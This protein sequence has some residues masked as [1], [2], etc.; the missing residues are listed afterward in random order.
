MAE[1][2]I[3]QELD[4]EKFCKVNNCQPVTNPVTFIKGGKPTPD[5]LLSE[6]IFGITHAERYGIYAYIDLNGWFLQPLAYKR[7]C[8]LNAKAKAVIYGTQTFSIKSGELIEDP[9]GDTGIR[10]L[11]TNFDKI[12]WS[13][14]E[15]DIAKTSMQYIKDL[16]KKNTLWIKKFPIIPPGYRDVTVTSKGVSIGELNQ[17]YQRLLMHTNALKQAQDYGLSMMTNAEGLIQEQMAS[18]F[19]WFG[20]GTTIGRDVTSNNLPGKTGIIRRSVLAKTTDYS[21]R[22]VITAP[23]N[24]VEDLD[25]IMVDMDHAAIPLA[26]AITC[27]KPFIL[28]WLRRFFEN[29]FAGKNFYNIDLYDDAF[30]VHQKRV[31]VPIKDYQAVF[32]DAELEKQIDRFAKGRYNRLIPIQVP[33]VDG[34][35]KKYKE[36]KGRKPYLYFTGYNI[37]G[38]ELAEARANNFEFNELIRRPLTWCDLFYMAA[39]DMTSDKSV[40]ITRFPMD[41]YFNQF[42]Q[43]INVITTSETVSMVVDGKFYKWYPKFNYKDIGKNTSAM[44]VDT[45]SI[46]NATIG[47]AGGDYDGDTVTCKPIFSIEANAEVRKQLNNIGNYNGLNGINAK[48][49]NKEGILCLYSLTNCPDKDTW[50]K[51]F[52]KM[53]F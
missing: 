4:V 22:S 53:E 35:E 21:C 45:I 37:K 19:N 16:E 26:I 46:N 39:V 32:S 50:N 36:L 30:K 11:K 6:Q 31:T 9:D 43:L 1:R 28:F 5:G 52:N 15:S 2:L 12:K 47:T 34:A 3:V 29:E 27:F 8:R 14:S 25:D 42:P 33:I 23:N 48:K 17:L 10:W 20:N 44:F 51:K 49:V 40:L 41:S 24:K 18:I 13:N 38:N 7:L